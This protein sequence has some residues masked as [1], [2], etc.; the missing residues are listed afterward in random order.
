M[1]IEELK[2]GMELDVLVAEYI[3]GET[4]PE[5]HND[6]QKVF[7]NSIGTIPSDN[8]ISEKGAWEETCIFSNEDIPERVPL[9]FSTD[10]KFAMGVF[11]KV[12]KNCLFIKKIYDKD[13]KL[14]W[15]VYM[16][17][18][19]PKCC[20]SLPEAICLAALAEI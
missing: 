18:K 8:L 17:Q 19:S 3:F 11:E 9:P 2:A 10:I 16:S 1:N 15:N 5:Y 13:G 7:H 12:N 20:Q 6:P 14:F 4:K